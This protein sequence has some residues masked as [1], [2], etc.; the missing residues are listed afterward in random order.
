MRAQRGASAS[1]EV[2]SLDIGWGFRGWAFG[3]EVV[4][5]EAQKELMRLVHVWHA[6]MLSHFSCVRPCET[7]CDWSVPGS[8]FYGIFQGKNTAVGCQALLQEIFLT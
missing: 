5:E 6:C 7:L 8:S 3:E 1:F 4:G 2:P